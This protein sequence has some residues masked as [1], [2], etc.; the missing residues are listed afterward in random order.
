MTCED[1]AKASLTMAYLPALEASV[2]RLFL[3]NQHWRKVALHYA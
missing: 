3:F 1:L 2:E